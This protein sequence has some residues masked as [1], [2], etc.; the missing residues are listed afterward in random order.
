MNLI[1][2]EAVKIRPP[3]NEETPFIQDPIQNIH[4]ELKNFE[5]KTMGN[6]YSFTKHIKVFKLPLRLLS[7][8]KNYGFSGKKFKKRFQS[9]LD[10]INKHNTVATFAITANSLRKNSQFIKNADGQNIEFA[11]HGYKHVDYSQLNFPEHLRHI[12]KAVNIFNENKINFEG[13]RC[14]YLRYNDNTFD[15]LNMYS[16]LWDNSSGIY[17]E[18]LDDYQFKFSKYYHFVKFLSQCHIKAAD[19]FVSIPKFVNNIVEIPV[20]LP[21]DELLTKCL[22]IKNKE[23]LSNI[24]INILQ[25]TFKRGELFTVQ[26]NPERIKY[27]DRAIHDLIYIS[28]KLK[29]KVWLT[30]LKNIAEWWKEKRGFS[31][32]IDK[33]GAHKYKVRVDCSER[34]MVLIKTKGDNRRRFYKNYGIIKRRKF[35]LKSPRLPIVGVPQNSNFYLTAFLKNEGFLCERGNTAL[36]YSVY[37]HDFANFKEGDEMKVLR[38]IDRCRYPIIRFWRWPEGHRSAMAITSEIDGITIKDFLPSVL[39]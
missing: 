37:L 33:V 8:M 2:S 28:N 1:Y 18:V 11:I 26:L 7:I 23:L 39:N 9:Y 20:S 12:E 3:V 14:P 21:D 13:F 15:V 30:S 34:A 16:I 19:K 36:D 29:P 25:Q 4:T 10:L 27:Y 22:K 17:W 38:R 32:E 5:N 24:W 6:G 31:L 35:T